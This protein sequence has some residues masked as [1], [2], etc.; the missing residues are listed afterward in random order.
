VV[1]KTD[2]F[3]T[4]ASAQLLINP[5]VSPDLIGGDVDEGYGK[6]VDIFRRN[7][8]SGQDVGTAVGVYRD[9]RK[10]V[11]LWGGFRSGITQTPCEQDTIV[12]VFSTT[13]G[14]AFA[15]CCGWRIER[16]HVV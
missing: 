4:S 11:D 5:R 2:H 6:V 3:L 1:T 15:G 8:S 14:V 16:V 13:K 9:G 12:N 7:L 10:V